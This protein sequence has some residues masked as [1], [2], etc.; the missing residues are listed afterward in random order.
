MDVITATSLGVVALF[1]TSN[2]IFSATQGHVNWAIG[3]WFAIGG[4]TGMIIG[5]QIAKKISSKTLQLI[6]VS[7]SFLTAGGLLFSIINHV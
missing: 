2:I 5:R 1:G 7:I 3:T 6:Y 4:G